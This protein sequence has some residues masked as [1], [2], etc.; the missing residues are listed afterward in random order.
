MSHAISFLEA[1]RRYG[2]RSAREV[3]I[4]L[5]HWRIL[6]CR[7]R[8][9]FAAKSWH[10]RLGALDPADRRRSDWYRN[11]E[12]V[13]GVWSSSCLEAIAWLLLP[14]PCFCPEHC[15]RFHLSE[16]HQDDT[17]EETCFITLLEQSQNSVVAEQQREWNDSSV[18]LE[19]L[20]D[21]LYEL[22]QIL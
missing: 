3:D 6:D 20:K 9:Q 18:T 12:L 14:K 1:S 13:F 2:W 22:D 16:R 15:I 21:Q 10:H 19:D 4:L 5:G 11:Q 17:P 7:Y 8:Q